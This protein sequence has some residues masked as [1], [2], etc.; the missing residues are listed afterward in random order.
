LLDVETFGNVLDVTQDLGLRGVALAP[1]PLLLE[2]FRET[3]RVVQTLDVAARAGVSV[4][5]PR[6]PHAAGGIEHANSEPQSP[7]PMQ[8]V[9]A[10]EP[11]TDD[12]RVEELAVVSR[13]RFRSHVEAPLR[14]VAVGGRRAF[15]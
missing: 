11:R 14:A 8:H 13:L 12:D 15:V 2:L 6:A 10:R 4:P 9:Q 7:Q 3:V 5:V 1:L